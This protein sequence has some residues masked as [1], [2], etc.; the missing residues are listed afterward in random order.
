MFCL[1][2]KVQIIMESV[3]GATS[4]T[5]AVQDGRDAGQTIEHVHLHVLPRIPNDFKRNDEVYEKLDS[6]DKGENIKWRDESD[7]ITECNHI[8]DHIRN[9]SPHLIQ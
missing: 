6:H 8:R 9:K 7:M 4:S 2:Q 5:I 3:H 1:A